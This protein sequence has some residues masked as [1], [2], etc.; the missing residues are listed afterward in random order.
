MDMKKDKHV[1]NENFHLCVCDPFILHFNSSMKVQTFSLELLLMSY[2]LSVIN[3]GSFDMNWKKIN[4]LFVYPTY[5]SIGFL[6]WW[7]WSDLANLQRTAYREA[8]KN[9]WENNKKDR[10]GKFYLYNFFSS[11]EISNITM[12]FS[13]HKIDD[14]FS[15]I[16]YP[17]NVYVWSFIALSFLDYST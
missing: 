10:K 9:P 15:R 11:I 6:G 16:I 17:L 2:V 3:L 4:F 5:G 13:L 14:F 12:I 1:W 8:R 7:W